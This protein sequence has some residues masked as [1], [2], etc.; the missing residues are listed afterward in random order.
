MEACNLD[1]LRNTI[2]FARAN[3]KNCESTEV[4]PA[5]QRAVELAAVL[6]QSVG[7]DNL[8]S[9]DMDSKVEMVSSSLLQIRSLGDVDKQAALGTLT[10]LKKL[11]TN[12]VSHPQEAKFQRVRLANKA[13]QTK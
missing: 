13:I 8:S 10:V 9:S 7:G 5:L 3:V 12:F 6:Q 2:A 1:V 11:L 4:G